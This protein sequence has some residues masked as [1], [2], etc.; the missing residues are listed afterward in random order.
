[1]MAG[2]A[3]RPLIWVLKGL[4]A[5]DTAQAMALAL[6]LG[7]RVEGKQLAFNAAHTLPNWLA[8]ARVFHLTAE[9]RSL[10]RP[11]WPD[12]VVATGRRTAPAA[13]WIKQQS[14]GHC[15]AVLLG[16][17]R[18]PLEAFD[19]VVTT[20]QYGL[21]QCPNVAL[22]PLPFA[23]AKQ[24]DAASLA[25][26][27]KAWADLPRPITL[28]VIGGNKFP[29]RLDAGDLRQFG[30][31]LEARCKALNGS[32][33]LLDSPR[34]PVGAAERV[35]AAMTVPKWLFQREKPGNPYQAAL[36]LC[37]EMIVTSDSV[38]MVT[39]MLS[40]GKPTWIFRLAVSPWSLRW[41]ART[42][43]L[44]WLARTGLLVPPRNVDGFMQGLLDQKLIGNIEVG[45][46]PVAHVHSRAAHES[47]IHRIKA[48]LAA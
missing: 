41:S 2:V 25:T 6:Q 46:A 40:T 11:P 28:A 35:A 32:V 43:W 19:L 4:R 48:M 9:A 23:T 22:V 34:S 24:V 20:P 33:V 27:R 18:M 36:G 1:M 7:G 5:G 10:L 8:G 21:P 17:P 47:V 14:N 30:L 31:A 26:F 37:D 42:G 45:D 12:L 44:A 13:L 15:K 38:S 16:R 39:E 29:L 3:T